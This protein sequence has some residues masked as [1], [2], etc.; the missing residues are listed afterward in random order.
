MASDTDLQPRDGDGPSL[1]PAH[2]DDALRLSRRRG[3]ETGLERGYSLIEP[4]LEREPGLG[5][6]KSS[7]EHARQSSEPGGRADGDTGTR[8][9]SL[10]VGDVP[11]AL[12]R[13]YYTEP[14]RFGSE[15]AFSID[16]TSK[17]PAFRDI[18]GALATRAKEPDVVRDMVAIAV[19]RGWSEIRVSGSKDFTREVW[20]AGKAQG[21]EVQGYKPTE[22]DLQELDR[23]QEARAG[24]DAQSSS[25]RTELSPKGSIPSRGP[26]KPREAAA[27]VDFDEG[28]SGKL[29]EVGQAPYRNK[30]GQ[31][32]SPF[33]KVALAGGK[34]QEVWGVSLSESVEKAGVKVGDTIA[35]RRDG[36]DAVTK[37]IE[38]RD[39]ASG[40]TSIQQRPVNRNRWVIEAERFRD[41]TPAE[42]AR[43]PALRNA[44]GRLAIIAAVVKDRLKDPLAQKR[45]IAAAKEHIAGHLAEGGQFPAVVV[46]EPQRATEK[47]LDAGRT[48]L[49]TND[50]EDDRSQ[51]PGPERTRSR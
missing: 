5:G 32:L 11:E 6:P 21:L 27:R 29:V 38:V 10:A 17:E 41:A 48:T 31:E 51:R 19:H 4:V 30:P 42:A 15:M 20:L 22:R 43:D 8:K 34:V 28:F 25:G 9:A 24:R 3:W 46:T 50:K 49:P 13:R 33:I 37:T 47:G 35:V 2:G 18:G 36:K 1:A 7:V 39:K 26:D 12:L 40:E 16:A 14:R 23:R 45:V 44:Q